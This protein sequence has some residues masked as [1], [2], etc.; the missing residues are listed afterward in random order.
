MKNRPPRPPRGSPFSQGRETWDPENQ[1]DLQFHYHREE[2]LSQLPPETRKLL[3]GKRKKI[4]IEKRNFFLIINILVLMAIIGGV[5][6][7]RR[8]QIG[9]VR[10]ENCRLEFTAL[11]YNDQVLGSLKITALGENEPGSFAAADF[12]FSPSEVVERADLLPLHPGEVRYLRAELSPAPDPRTEL[13][14]LV[15]IGGREITLRQ[16]PRGE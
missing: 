14:V 16:I 6:L 5:S 7:Y 12:F 2:R 1:G 10:L 13:R 4:F 8:F 3:Y 9:G 15:R 11:R